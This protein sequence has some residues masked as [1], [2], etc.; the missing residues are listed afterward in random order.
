MKAG[1]AIA[2][3]LLAISAGH[4]GAQPAPASAREAQSPFSRATELVRLVNAAAETGGPSAL[5]PYASDMERALIEDGWR[6]PTD[7][8]VVLVDGRQETL[9]AALRSATAKP[10]PPGVVSFVQDPYLPISLALGSYYNEIRNPAEAARALTLGVDI[11][12]S[13]HDMKL[14]EHSAAIIGERGVAY[15]QM[16]QLDRAMADYELCLTLPLNDA[17]KARM[18]RGRGFVLIEMGRLDDAEAAYATSLKF[19]PGNEIALRE[20]QYINR[21]R[22]GGPRAAPNVTI[23]KP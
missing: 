2:V 14:A 7:P 5:A 6:A 1:A 20:V 3:A 11:L 16:G 10:P 18:H 13:R 23:A 8:L 17:E 4:A 9:A 22:Q 15:G 12:K 21:L 19:A